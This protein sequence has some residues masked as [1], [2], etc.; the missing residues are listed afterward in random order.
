M[1]EWRPRRLL[2]VSVGIG[3]I[4]AILLLDGVLVRIG[5]SLSMSFVSFLLGLLIVLSIP[6]AAVLGYLVYGLLTMK[7]LIGRDSVVISWAGRKETIPLA[8]IESVVPLGE[9]GS[10]IKS[11]GIRIPGQSIRR[12]RDDRGGEVLFYSNGRGPDELLIRTAVK[13][14]IV[15]P[16]KPTAFIT[17]VG[18]R[19]RLG[20]ARSLEQARQERGLVGLS[21]WRDWTALGLAVAGA[22][23]NG[24]LFAYIS[25]RYPYLPEIV[26]LLSEAGR[27]KLIGAKAELF[28]LPVLGLTVLV[29]NTVLGFVLH[30]W[31]RPVTYT[32]GAIALLVQILV[33]SAAIS[34]MS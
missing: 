3:S 30:R 27:V 9:L 7:Y 21:V 19:R 13:S 15:S 4:L 16:S 8:A 17:A 18:A 26:P 1:L 28:E 32:L 25:L 34:V 12:G 11:K 20:P 2:G 29:V 31:E 6:I 5:S 14:Y 23:A 33:W 10:T 22:V 24:G